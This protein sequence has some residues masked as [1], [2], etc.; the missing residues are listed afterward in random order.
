L[1]LMPALLLASM[2]SATFAQDFTQMSLVQIASG[3]NQPIGVV[4]TG[5]GGKRL[6]IVE[7][8]G[9]IRILNSGTGSLNATPFLD[10]STQIDSGGNEQGLLGLVF[11]PDYASNGYSLK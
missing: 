4:N 9:V 11:H 2:A 1:R 3:L 8:A 7:Q 5:D 10:I 6:F